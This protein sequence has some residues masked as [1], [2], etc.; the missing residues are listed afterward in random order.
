MVCA[1]HHQKEEGKSSRPPPISIEQAACQQPKRA[2]LLAGKTEVQKGPCPARTGMSATGR[3]SHQ[4]RTGARQPRIGLADRRAQQASPMKAPQRRPDSVGAGHARDRKLAPG[5]SRTNLS[6]VAVAGSCKNTGQRR[7]RRDRIRRSA[8]TPHRRRRWR[9]WWRTGPW[10]G[11][12]SC[13]LW[14]HAA[15]ADFG[16]GSPGRARTADP[17]INSHLLYRLSYRGIEGA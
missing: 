4:K 7:Q 3:R 8:Q 17:V 2:W 15:R 9:R 12:R 6:N 14:K 11:C 16:N 5:C 10:A 1:S 13:A